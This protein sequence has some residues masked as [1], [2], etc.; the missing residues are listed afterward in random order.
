MRSSLFVM[1]VCA[2][3][4][5]AARADL[6]D[7]L[8]KSAE[9]VRRAKAQWTQ[10][11]LPVDLNLDG[12]IGAL[13]K[14]IDDAKLNEAGRTVAL[15]YRGDA[16]LL[17]NAA[18]ANANRPLNVD[19]ARE[20][21]TDYDRV[22][23][24]GKDIADWGVDVSNAAYH[25]GWVAH[26]QLNSI[27]LAYS[28]WEKC[29]DMGH[30]GCL[31]TVAAARVSGAGGVK[32]D[33][34]Q[35]LAMNSQVFN[36]G[37]NYGCAGAY[38]ARNNALIIYFTKTRRPA[39]EALEWL[40]R[41]KR[42]LD[43]LPANSCARARFDVLEYLVRYSG[44]D[45]ARAAAL[46]TAM[47][48]A[49][50]DADRGVVNYLVDGKEDAFRALIARQPSK[51]GKCDLHFIAMWNAEVNRNTG[52][53]RDHYRAMQEVGPEACGPELAYVKKFGR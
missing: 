45:G 41:S 7:D 40:D 19:T 27:A 5:G 52:L 34:D 3:A 26:R 50:S 10:G 39:G 33:V 8:K 21:L 12:E 23:K 46:K 37:I 1:L 53:S 11:T 24:Y 31:M 47:Q 16:N 20:A 51:A 30:Y 44:N 15:Y 13:T 14:I 43:A 4:C 32:V 48:H 29:A 28:Y 9:S 35:A 25:A 49:A 22:I 2:F 18:R 38:A 17:V 36:S 6:A 42:L